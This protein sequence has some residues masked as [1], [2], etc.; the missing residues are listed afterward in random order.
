MNFHVGNSPFTARRRAADVAGPRHAEDRA[1][2]SPR[3][4]SSTPSRPP[5]STLDELYGVPRPAPSATGP[6]SALCMI[7][8]LDGTTVVDGRSGG[9][10]NADRHA[11]CSAPCAGPPTSSSSAPAT[12]RAG[13]LRAAAASPASASAW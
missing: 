9:L 8:S 4:A 13:G 7:A 5:T 11:P 3:C 12:V 6:G 1:H 2:A 10:G